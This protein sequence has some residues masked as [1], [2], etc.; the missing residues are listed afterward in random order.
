MTTFTTSTPSVPA[1]AA[2]KSSKQRV[3]VVLGMH[4]SGTSLL[5]NLLTVL[6]VDVGTNLLAA[7]QGNEAGYWENESIYRTQDALLNFIAKDWG[8]YGFAYPF[9]I[10][11]TRLPEMRDFQE[12]LT[13]IVRAEIARA[14]GIWGFKDPRTCRLLPIWKQIFTELDLEP[15][16]V[17]AIRSPAVVVE[18]LL[19]LYPLDALHGELV[20]LLYYLDAIRDAGEEL[21]IVVDYDRWFTEPLAQAKAVATA[22]ELAWPIDE[23]D[24]VA[25]LTQTIRPDLRRSKARRPCALPFV[26][27]THEALRQAAATG[28]APDKIVSEY[29]R[30]AS[31][32]LAAVLEL[33]AGTG[34]ITLAVGQAE[35]QAGNLEAAE[36]AFTRATRLQPKLA[37]AYSNR[38]L[39][40][41]SLG[42]FSEALDSVQHAIS[43]DPTDAVALRVWVK[44]HL[45]RGQLED[46]EKICQLLLQKNAEDPQTLQTLK[47]VLDHKKRTKRAADQLFTFGAKTVSPPRIA[48]APLR[49]RKNGAAPNPTAALA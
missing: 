23:S 5:T 41:L 35:L 3:V 17:L 24:L 18:S 19:K 8:A 28:Q 4:R 42:R 31:E 1:S 9:A 6:G 33:S 38:G 46:A 36:A 21:R 11:W 13:A 12:R 43:L 49:L 32:C 25:R 7:N 30:H 26:T 10:D 15:L 44:I 20:W 14:K 22:L 37:P 39:A 2:A 34:P 48:P 47:E 45:Q 16:Y 40:L 27:K 29:L